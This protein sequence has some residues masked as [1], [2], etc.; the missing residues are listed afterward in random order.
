[1]A[2]QGKKWHVAAAQPNV[3]Q[4]FGKVAIGAA[5]A[6]T[7]VGGKGFTV[8]RPGTG[9]YNIVLDRGG[10]GLGFQ[11]LVL[12]C[13]CSVANNSAATQFTAQVSAFANV[14]NT[15]TLFTSA[16]ATP[17]VAADPPNGSFLYFN[18]AYLAQP[19]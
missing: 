4:V 19:S 6:P 18:L 11:G 8:T 17:N 1:M 12:Y 3:V 14:G 10:G 5:G 9:T 7:T 15:T 2:I 16:A 13:S